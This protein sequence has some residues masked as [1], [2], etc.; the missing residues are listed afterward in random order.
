MVEETNEGQD[1]GNDD[2]HDVEDSGGPDLAALMLPM[3]MG[4]RSSP[5]KTAEGV[6]SLL[7]ATAA[8]IDGE[9]KPDIIDVTDPDTGITVLATVGR[10]GVRAL[11]DTF[12]DGARDNPRFRRGTATL[13]SLDSFIA[14]VNR[15][16]DADSVVFAC[17]DRD[18]PKLTAVL[19]YH[20]ADTLGDGDEAVRGEY[21][22]GKHRSVF[23]FPLS[24]EWKAWNKANA[25]VMKMAEFALFLEDRIGDIALA[26]DDLP[27][28]LGKF[29][30]VN[31]G[32]DAIAD[33]AALIELSRGLKV[34]ENSQVEEA[35]NLASG[36]GHIRFS[37]EHETRTRTGG[38]LKVPTMFFI[39]IPIFHKG[40]FYRIAARLRYR[41][42]VEGVVFWFDLYRADKS[43]NH[44]FA[45]AVERVE[46]ETA[47][48]V[49]F[50]SP[51]A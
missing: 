15:F 46:N 11:P 7:S 22:H 8:F 23:A 4:G 34:H 9:L 25:K 32:P 26:G 12:F 37:V 35:T 38:T 36:E 42:T 29:I 39:A 27:E 51:E 13:T 6:G 50:G 14:H 43:F 33:Y 45:E 16:G 21:R 20:R 18:A 48:T 5:L 47:A 31:G 30:N 41:K 1:I 19:D 44:A 49:L 17:D 10:E 28:E 24:D 40:A 2:A 3:L